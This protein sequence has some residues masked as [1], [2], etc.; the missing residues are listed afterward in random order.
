MLA[1]CFCTTELYVPVR[2]CRCVFFILQLQQ[3]Q[4]CASTYT[5]AFEL[6]VFSI[7]HNEGK[8]RVYVR[9]A[10]ALAVLECSGGNHS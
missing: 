1:D 6:D 5:A 4:Y 3:Q 2:V 7:N 8:Q 10:N 9:Y